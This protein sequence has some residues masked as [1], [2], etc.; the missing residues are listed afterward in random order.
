MPVARAQVMYS[1]YG[2]AYSFAVSQLVNA[3]YVVYGGMVLYPRMVCGSSVTAEMRR[4]PQSKFFVMGLL[5]SLG[6]F[7]AAMGSV[8][9]PGQLQVR[10]AGM[11]AGGRAD[12]WHSRDQ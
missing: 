1:V 5:D 9:T 10:Q 3:M 2:A 7:L 11:R 12:I 4:Y 8:H 6:T